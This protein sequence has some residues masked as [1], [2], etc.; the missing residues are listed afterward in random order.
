MKWIHLD[1]IECAAV[2]AR[3]VRERADDWTSMLE[4]NLL[5]QLWLRPVSCGVRE[6]L[7][8]SASLG[9]HAWKRR[10]IGS[11]YTTNMAAAAGG[12]GCQLQAVSLRWREVIVLTR[13]QREARARGRVH[14]SACD[15]RIV[16]PSTWGGSS[17]PAAR[18][19]AQRTSALRHRDPR[20]WG[21]LCALRRHRTWVCGGPGAAFGQGA[22]TGRYRSKYCPPGGN[23]SGAII[24]VRVSVSFDIP[25]LKW[26]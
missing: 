17:A 5:A 24:V 18:R 23:H 22:Q 26:T 4:H 6:G 21:T 3:H 11:R 14:R 25:K 15:T 13:A 12:T 20:P 9:A 16:S 19:I 7:C 10:H 2:H 1:W 8:V